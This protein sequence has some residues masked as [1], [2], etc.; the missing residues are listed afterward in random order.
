M[1]DFNLLMISAAF[2]SMGNVTHRHFDSHPNIF[3][4][5]FESQIGT[6]YSTNLLDGLLPLRYRYSVFPMGTT[7]EQAYDLLWDEEQKL[8]LRHPERSKFR[9]CGQK[10]NENIRRKVFYDYCRD[11]PLT[12]RLFVEAYFVSTF[13]AWENYNRSGKETHYLGYNPGMIADTDK[14]FEDFPDAHIIHVIRNPLSC[15]ADYLKRPYPGSLT[16]YCSTWNIIQHLSHVYR[17]KYKGQFHIVRVEDYMF[18]KAIVFGEILNNLSLPWSDTMLYP[19]FNGKKLD[20][21]YPW[22][23]IV[24]PTTE[25]NVQTALQLTK[26]QRKAV[27]T[28]TSLMIDVFGYR[29][30]IN[31]LLDA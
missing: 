23:T 18:N 16:Q 2:E 10:M 9:D 13:E 11:K 27:E 29:N 24:T 3:C 4:Y 7:P 14:L 21:V 19:S 1:S 8:F 12:R 31:Q 17:K 20:S 5:G 15:Y 22:G 25:V 30:L 26:D 6:K 28:E